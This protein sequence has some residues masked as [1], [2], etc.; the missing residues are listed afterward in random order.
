MDGR[1]PG[2]LAEWREVYAAEGCL[3]EYPE[4]GFTL[5]PHFD[6]TFA[7]TNEAYHLG[8]QR[9]KPLQQCPPAGIPNA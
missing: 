1:Q 7:L 5:F 8:Q 4:N 6:Q 9:I 3:A 2:T